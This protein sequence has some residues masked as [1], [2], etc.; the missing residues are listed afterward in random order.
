MT[1]DNSSSINFAGAREI[2]FLTREDTR[3]PNLMR[4]CADFN[5]RVLETL[6]LSD[7]TPQK[8]FVLVTDDY[9]QTDI[10]AIAPHCSTLKA[11][12]A[13]VEKHMTDILHDYLFGFVDEEMAMAQSLVG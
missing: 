3:F 4:V 5:F 2:Q 7:T 6:S 12:D 9:R 10:Q 13:H 8:S 1:I 11:L